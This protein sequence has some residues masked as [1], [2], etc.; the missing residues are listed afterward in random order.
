MS[1]TCVM[2]QGYPHPAAAQASSILSMNGTMVSVQY[3]QSSIYHV[4]PCAPSPHPAHLHRRPPC[5]GA[6]VSGPT[7]RSHLGSGVFTAPESSRC[8]PSAALGHPAASKLPSAPGFS[9]G[10]AGEEGAR[11]GGRRRRW[12]WQ[13]LPPSRLYPG[14]LCGEWCVRFPVQSVLPGPR[15][16][17]ASS[18]YTSRSPRH[19][20]LCSRRA[21]AS[22]AGCDWLHSP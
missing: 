15:P 17:G 16:V 3:S 9:D 6:D 11:E 22:L 10:G 21:G 4:R 8:V 14:F 18:R 2:C 7:A 12:R 5:H 20:A 19:R 1:R 13:A